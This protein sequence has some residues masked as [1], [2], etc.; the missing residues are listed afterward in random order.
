MLTDARL[1]AALDTILRDIEAPPVPLAAIRQRVARAQPRP[2]AALRFYLPACAAT[3]AL[4]VFA[5]TAIAPGFTQTIEA[6]IE[7]ILQW[8]PPPPPPFAVDSA[9]RSQNGT[10]AAAQSRVSFRIVP[11]AGLPKDV[12]SER[13]VTTPAGA[14]SKITHSWSVGSPAVTFTYRRADGRTF[15]LMADRFDPR[16]GPP[17]RY[18]FEGMDRMH[19]GRE[20]MVRRENF[21]WRNGDQSMSAVAGEGIS[22]SEITAVRDAMD[23]IAVP[24]TWPPRDGT[25]VKQYRIP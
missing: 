25:I 3:A 14:Y 6:Q 12:V 17:S 2:R 9:M 7:A 23:G 22:A 19:N 1:A 8:K 4:L 24:G 13:I 18:V 10:L 16:E 11:P 20:V 15:M 5:L 21:T